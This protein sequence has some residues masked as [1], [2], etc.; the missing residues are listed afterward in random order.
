MLASRV[1]SCLL[2]TMQAKSLIQNITFPS[3][4]SVDLIFLTFARVCLILRTVPSLAPP[5]FHCGIVYLITA[6]HARSWRILV[7]HF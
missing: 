2:L 4:P 6:N 3:P 1:P 7:T 5:H